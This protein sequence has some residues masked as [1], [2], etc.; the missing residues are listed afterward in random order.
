VMKYHGAAL[1]Y[2]PIKNS[3]QIGP[4][5]KLSVDERNTRRMRNRSKRLVQ[6]SVRRRRKHGRTQR[7]A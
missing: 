7:T 2:S 5:H 6:M 4:K 3:V 1:G